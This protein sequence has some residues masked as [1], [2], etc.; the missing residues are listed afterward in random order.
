MDKILIGDNM[1]TFLKS[2]LTRKFLLALGSF[3]TLVANG[4]YTEALG[5]V[6]AYIL[7]EGAADTV[8]RVKSS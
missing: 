4:Q 3:I 5:V 2:L 6:S 7:A 8:S 1:K